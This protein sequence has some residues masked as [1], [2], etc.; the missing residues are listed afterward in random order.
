M[1]KWLNPKW[2]SSV[3][4]TVIVQASIK[5][6]TTWISDQLNI[7]YEDEALIIV[8]KAPGMVVH[9]AAGSPDNT[10]LNALLH[11][12]RPNC[13]LSRAPGLFIV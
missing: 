11:H 8:N 1:A 12:T 3:A 13:K 9:P 10:M 4:E 7:I 5:P 6:Q 2:R